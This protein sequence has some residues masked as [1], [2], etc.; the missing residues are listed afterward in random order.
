[1]NQKT[2]KTLIAVALVL[3]LLLSMCSIAFAQD[4]MV[5]STTS[6][7]VRNSNTKGTVSVSATSS[8][9][10]TPYMISKLTL[11][12]APLGSSNFVN[13]NVDPKTKQ[14]A[15]ASIAHVATFAITTT[16]EYRVKIELTDNTKGVDNTITF[17][18]NLQE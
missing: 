17:Y 18:E 15:S 10:L 8:N 3:G 1:M 5:V 12:E 11:Q 7:F 9:P 14:V 16:K 6:S 13:S 4:R 2:L